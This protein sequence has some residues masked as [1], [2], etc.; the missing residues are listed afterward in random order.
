MQKAAKRPPLLFRACDSPQAEDNLKKDLK[1]KRT[2]IK[3]AFYDGSH[4]LN[5][6]IPKGKH[7]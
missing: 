4:K 6:I 3:H 1:E 2:I 5:H 7:L